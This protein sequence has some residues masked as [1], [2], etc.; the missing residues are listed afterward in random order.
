MSDLIDNALSQSADAYR[1]Q[2][3]AMHETNDDGHALLEFDLGKTY[4]QE[5][6]A[7]IRD[8]ANPYLLMIVLGGVVQL[9]STSMLHG[10]CR[11][12]HDAL[13]GQP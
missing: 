11:G 3:L 6:A 13:G 9:R 12:L 1:F 7:A 4:A 10:L 5:I 8:G 2:T